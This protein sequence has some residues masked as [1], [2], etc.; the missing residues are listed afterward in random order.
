M[1]RNY[2]IG[3]GGIGS[4]L[5]PLLQK[6]IPKDEVI[7]PMDGDRIEQRNFDRQLHLPEHF[8]WNKAEA[9]SFQYMLGDFHPRYLTKMTRPILKVEDW[10]WC[11]VDNHPARRECLEWIDDCDASGVFGGNEYESGQAYIYFSNWKDTALDPRIRFPEILTDKSGDPN[12]PNCQGAAQEAAPQLA[13][14]NC[15][16]A[17]QMVQLYWFFIRD[18]LQVLNEY[19][20]VEHVS[21]NSRLMTFQAY[22]FVKA[23]P[24][25]VLYPLPDHR[26]SLQDIEGANP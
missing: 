3:C 9:I 2:V 17:S 1:K 19:W 25:D 23:G 16:V 26:R 7:I 20:P 22:Q 11:A 13:L 10:V 6:M 15:L 14:Y 5:V 24:N 21:S 4:W 8:S 12:R 18:S